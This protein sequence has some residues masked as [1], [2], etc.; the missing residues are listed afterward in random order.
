MTTAA[1]RTSDKRRSKAKA[2]SASLL[3]WYDRHRRSLPW[4]AEP[5]SAVDP[6]HVLVSE[7]ML[8]QTTVATVSGRFSPFIQRFP[9]IESLAEAEEADVLHAW[10]GLGY[11]RRARALHAAA[12]CIIADHGG[13]LPNTVEALLALPGIGEYTAKAVAAI[14]F[15][16]PV[17]PVDGNGVRVLS[18]M[19]AIETPLPRAANEARA[20]ALPFEPCERPSDL[21]QAVMD[22]G[23][24]VCRPR[25]PL[26]D[27]CPWQSACAGHDAGIA[28]SLPRRA[29]KAKRPLRQGVAFLLTR[30]DG[31]IL[32]RRRPPDGLLGGLHELPTSQ[33][34]LAP[35]DRNAAL[36]EAP[37]ALDWHFHERPVR[38][39][40]THFAL[41]L[42]LA[43]ATTTDPPDGLW[44]P[45]DGLAAL[46]LPTLV[47][48]LLRQ[49]GRL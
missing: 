21:A 46:A 29:P 9:N 45:P 41:D 7:L 6:Y 32:F 24:T 10:Q 4:R 30:P 37:A 28:E 22:L 40:F 20:A 8:Q 47:K 1:S 25:Q 44:Q 17:L 36:D 33:W 13:R 15:D 48:K 12:R 42:E 43:E 26:C 49:A 16:R 2:L 11:Y 38:H 35:L 19:F 23:A 27:R 18:R 3:A 5:C 14:A 39:V 34:L 31:A